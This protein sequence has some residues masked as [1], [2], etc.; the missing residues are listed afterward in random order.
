MQQINAVGKGLVMGEELQHIF[1][2]DAKIDNL[3]GEF[4]ELRVELSAFMATHEKR[5]VDLEVAVAELKAA[6][7]KFERMEWVMGGACAVGGSILT[8]LASNIS[9][10]YAFVKGGLL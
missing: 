9:K 5:V 7:K 6:N 10:V 1:N 8:L 4:G 3:R 2:L